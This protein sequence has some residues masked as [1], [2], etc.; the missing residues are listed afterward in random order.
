MIGPQRLPLGAHTELVC[1]P[2]DKGHARLKNK[3]KILSLLRLER[4][5]LVISLW[6]TSQP[7][8]QSLAPLGESRLRR[9]AIHTNSREF[10]IFPGVSSVTA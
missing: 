9:F 6:V 4:V 7:A 8:L 1:G 2:S 3:Q 10:I 5:T